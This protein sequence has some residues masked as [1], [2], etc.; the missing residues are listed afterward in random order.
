MQK[1]L[2]ISD[3]HGMDLTKIVE[4]H[5]DF[6][7]IHCGDWCIN[8]TKLDELGIIYVKGN[9]DITF[10]DTDKLILL[11]GFKVYITHG[12]MYGVKTGYMNLYYKALESQCDYCFFGHTHIKTSFEME[13]IKFL[14]P[15]S[16]KNGDYIEIIDGKIEFKRM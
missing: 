2:I 8:K 7:I 4:S 11:D 13:N 9:C 5:K 6:K 16:L 15:G 1:W 3:S 14:N 10:T 12:H